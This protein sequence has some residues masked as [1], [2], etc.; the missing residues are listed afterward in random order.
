MA[1]APK[2]ANVESLDGKFQ[3]QRQGSGWGRKKSCDEKK[4]LNKI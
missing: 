1:G 4:A 3:I 2:L